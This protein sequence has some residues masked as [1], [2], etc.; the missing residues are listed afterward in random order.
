MSVL[1]LIA[2]LTRRPNQSGSR[3][4]EEPDTPLSAGAIRGPTDEDHTSVVL[5]RMEHGDLTRA[6]RAVDAGLAQTPGDSALQMLR[7]RVLVQWHRYREATEQYA[8]TVTSGSDGAAFVEAGWAAYLHGNISSAHAYLLRAVE[9]APSADALFGL[10]VARQALGQHEMALENL[11]DVLALDSSY[12]DAWLNMGICQ[13]GR[14]ENVQAE[15]SLRKAL[16]ANPSDSYAWMLLAVALGSQSKTD[17]SLEAFKRS[18]E[19]DHS[20]KSPVG[21]LGQFALSL[22]VLGRFDA[23]VKLCEEELPTQPDPFAHSLYAWALL[24]TG[25]HAR[26]WPQYEFRWTQEPLKSDRPTYGVPRWK[27]QPLANKTILLWTEQGFGDTIQFGRFARTFKQ[28]G[29]RVT[30]KVGSGLLDLATCFTG[31]D[32][33]SAD[34]A[35]VGHFDYHIPLMSVP[36]ALGIVESEVPAEV[37]YLS[38]DELLQAQWQTRLV[39]SPKLRVGLV[40]A[41]NPQHGR[42]SERSIDLERFTALWQIEGVQFVSLQK[43]MR[44]G[45]EERLPKNEAAFLNAG[46]SLRSFSETAALISV[47][48]LVISVDTSVAHLAGALGKA[49]WLLSSKIPDFRWMEHRATSP[50]YP[51]MRLFREEQAD[52]WV[53]VLKR[54]AEELSIARDNRQHLLPPAVPHDPVAVV[55]RGRGQPEGPRSASPPRVSQ[56]LEMRDGLFQFL[57]EEDDEAR[58]LEFYGEYLVRHLSILDRILPVDADVLEY[59]SGVGSHAVWLGRRLSPEAQLICYEPRPVIRRILGHNLRANRATRVTFPRGALIDSDSLALLQD[60]NHAA[61]LHTVDDLRLTRLGLLKINDP[62]ACAAILGG[63]DETMWKLRPILLLRTESRAS[64]SAI[65]EIAAAHAY[66]CWRIVTPLFNSENF[67]RREV[68]LFAGRFSQALLGIPEERAAQP[69]GDLE[70]ISL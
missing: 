14:G 61:P 30:I 44:A 42:D 6:L 32:R 67:N 20:S 35:G 64:E 4:L 69:S 2:R 65:K 38:I 47:L 25:E 28:L 27:G 58:S 19:L 55:A 41:G 63:A 62:S 16:A 22:V 40:W 15:S 54:V 53:G 46:P 12:R 7:A 36:A 51:T 57:P 37:P 18:R 23:V 43:D 56:V 5:D 59:L 52:G 3:T 11:R 21:C 26:G 8:R 13:R 34:D 1:R 10:A 17:E 50:W 33:A 45:D 24:T 29:A 48:D 31:V 70:E 68:D 60:A 49:V 66:R 9:L 39:G